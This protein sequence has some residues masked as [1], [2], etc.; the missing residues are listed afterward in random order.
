MPTNEKSECCNAEIKFST[1]PD[2]FRGNPFCS[3]CSNPIN[4]SMTDPT[5][6]KLAVTPSVRDEWVALENQLTK[7]YW[8]ECQDGKGNTDFSLVDE[9]EDFST[10]PTNSKGEIRLQVGE[11]RDIIHEARKVFAAKQKLEEEKKWRM[12]ITCPHHWDCLEIINTR[13]ALLNNITS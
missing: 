11:L 3:S 8:I 6:S 1:T 12:N 7:F 5:L 13:K 9:S 10:I 2:K 4:D